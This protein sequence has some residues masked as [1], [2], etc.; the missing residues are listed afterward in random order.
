MARGSEGL[1]VLAPAFKCHDA[2]VRA[3]LVRCA[4][5]LGGDVAERVIEKALNDPDEKLRNAAEEALKSAK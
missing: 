5:K 2:K 1:P 3:E 4:K